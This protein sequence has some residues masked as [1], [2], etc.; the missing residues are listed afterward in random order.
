MLNTA[1]GCQVLSLPKSRAVSVISRQRLASRVAIPRFLMPPTRIF[2]SRNPAA[3]TSRLSTPR[4][5]PT[6]RTSLPMR[7]SSPATAIAGI[8]CPPVPPPAMTNKCEAATLALLTS[9]RVLGDVEQNSQRG[10]R[11]EQG[12]PAEADH[13]QRDSLRRDHPQHHAHV[14]KRLDHQHRRDAQC[15]VTAKLVGDQNC[16]TDA[17]PQDYDE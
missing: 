15:E 6:N 13:R 3:G 17:S 14:E 10:Q 4:S 7:R 8:T 12:T 16:R 11:D 9:T 1:A 2:S 5:V